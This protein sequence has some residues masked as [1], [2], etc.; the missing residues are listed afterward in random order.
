MK[1]QTKQNI[2]RYV[3]SCFT[4]YGI[5][6]LFSLFSL[7]FILDIMPGWLQFVVSFVFIAPT[8]FMLFSQGKVQGEKLFKLR[9]KTN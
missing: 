7:I 1:K 6:L 3:L 5:S 8:M 2:K 4:I 9:A